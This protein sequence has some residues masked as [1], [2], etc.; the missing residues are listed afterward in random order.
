M[1]SQKTKRDNID[2][3]DFYNDTKSLFK[4][5]L[6]YYSFIGFIRTLSCSQMAYDISH[7][8]FFDIVYNMTLLS[9]FV[10]PNYFMVVVGQ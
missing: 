6:N 7:I 1:I 4:H 8:R 9:Y 10:S 2:N 5:V 3:S